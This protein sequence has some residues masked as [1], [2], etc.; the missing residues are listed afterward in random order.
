MDKITTEKLNLYYGSF[1]AL[2][3]VDL[4]IPEREITALI[5]PLR[6][7]KIH[8]NQNAEPNE[9]PGGR[10]PHRWKSHFGQH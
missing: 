7:R 5:G 2:Q 10:L 6:L 4:R 3:N 9:R 8:P 1:Q